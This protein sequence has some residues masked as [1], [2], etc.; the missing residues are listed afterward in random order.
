MAAKGGGFRFVPSLG[1]SRIDRILQ[2]YVF[3]HLA[4]YEDKSLLSK[5]FSRKVEQ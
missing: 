1:N 4:S 2:F 3:V 5:F